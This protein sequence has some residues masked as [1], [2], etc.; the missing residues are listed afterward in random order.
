MKL[1][2]SSNVKVLL[3]DM[4]Y[5][6]SVFDHSDN[7]FKFLCGIIVRNLRGPTR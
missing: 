5:T 2:R 3:D 6:D 4:R 1:S 7:V